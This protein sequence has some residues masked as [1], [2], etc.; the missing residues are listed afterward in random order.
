MSYFLYSLYSWTTISHFSSSVR[1]LEA[2][3]EWPG[4]MTWWPGPGL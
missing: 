4:S 3:V 2:G 1:S